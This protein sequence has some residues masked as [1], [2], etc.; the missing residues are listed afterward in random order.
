MQVSIPALYLFTGELYPTI[1]RNAGVGAAVMFSRIGSMLAPL[2][3]A[4]HDVTPFLP[5]L[6]LAGMA[7]IEALLVIPLPETKGM[8]LP[9]KIEDLYQKNM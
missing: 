2:V 5:L 8:V 6:V 4:L 9:E 7:G 1:I 3:I